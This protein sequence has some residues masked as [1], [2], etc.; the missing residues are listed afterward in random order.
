MI[1]LVMGV[2]GSGKTTIGQQLAKSLNFQ[3]RDADE[4]HSDENI[5]KMRNNIPLTDADRQPWLETM[6]AAIDQ[7]LEQNKNVVLTCSALKDKY[8][9]MLWRDP[10]QIKIVYLKGT[11]ELIESRL[12]QRQDHFMKSD[13]LKSQF[14][15]L[16]EPEGVILADI[17]QTPSEIIEKIRKAFIL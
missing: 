3:F 6:Q 4:F 15:D 16:E 12:K 13:L 1:I 10:E 17:S 5:Q 11:F 9:K 8:R 2:S 14:E 7:W